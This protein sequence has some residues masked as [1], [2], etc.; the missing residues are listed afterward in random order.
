MNKLTKIYVVRH[1]Q[2]RFNAGMDF[3]DLNASLTDAGKEQAKNIAEKFKEIDFA[4]IFASSLARS[5]E[6][7]EIIKNGRDLEVE[8]NGKTDER[9]I[10]K[11]ARAIKREDADIEEEIMNNLRKLSDSEKMNYKLTSQM[12]SASEAAIRFIN[13]IKGVVKRY[14][15]KT[16]LIVSH[17]NMMR[18]LLT[19][20]G[21]AKYD[22]LPTGTVK[23]TGYFVL[24]TD[25]ED[26]SVVETHDIE[27][28]KDAIRVW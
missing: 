25:G 5:K 17:G 14:P 1:G 18:S 19:Q 23:N 2:S 4:A 22:E 3:E 13:F 9:S 24:E 7:A 28:Q 15:S 26:F 11:Y 20:L 10:Y 27:K 16:L 6:T 12:E 21:F 8:A